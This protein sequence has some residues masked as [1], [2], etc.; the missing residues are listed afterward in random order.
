[1]RLVCA[2][3]IK[4]ILCWYYEKAFKPDNMLDIRNLSLRLQPDAH[5]Y[6]HIQVG[7][8]T[9][10]AEFKSEK[11]DEVRTCILHK[12]RTYAL[13]CELLSNY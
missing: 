5:A 7:F 3:T 4:N 13:R 2:G 1:M 6:A 10:K 12:S 11:T 9:A 8:E